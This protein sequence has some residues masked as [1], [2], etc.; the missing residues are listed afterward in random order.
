MAVPT[1]E[2]VCEYAGVEEIP[3]PRA[4]VHNSQSCRHHR[5]GNNKTRQQPSSVGPAETIRHPHRFRRND[6]NS[7][8]AND[9]SQCFFNIHKSPF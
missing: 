6:E 2:Q 4:R 1:V 9:E 3:K 8:R 5:P 7:E